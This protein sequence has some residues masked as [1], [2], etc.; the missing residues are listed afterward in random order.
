VAL[1]IGAA[2]SD[3][4]CVFEDAPFEV[5]KRGPSEMGLI[6]AANQYM[7]D[8]GIMK[9]EDPSYSLLRYN[10]LVKLGKRYKGKIDPEVM[11]KI[12]ETPVTKNGKPAGGAM[13]PYTAHMEVCDVAK[14]IFWIKTPGHAEWT[15][16]DLSGVLVPEK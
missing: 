13:N 8:W 12:V 15:K 1:I 11:M 2:D 7:L 5:K 9:V 14:K 10:N 6:A 4:A 3:G 16:I